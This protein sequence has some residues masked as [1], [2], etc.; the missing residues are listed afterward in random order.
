MQNN[1]LFFWI[2]LLGIIMIEIENLL[3]TLASFQKLALYV[4]GHYL[5]S[6]PMPRL[7][8]A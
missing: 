1:F 6:L 2:L 5:G 3:A 8:H 7:Y 4:H